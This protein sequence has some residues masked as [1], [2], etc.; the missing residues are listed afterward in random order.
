MI[1]LIYVHC[2]TYKYNENSNHLIAVSSSQPPLLPKQ[3]CFLS[4]PQFEQVNHNS[5]SKAKITPVK[6]TNEKR[7]VFFQIERYV[8]NLQ[9]LS[10][11]CHFGRGGVSWNVSGAYILCRKWIL[12]WG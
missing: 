10:L 5:K 7:G 6:S 1:V 4:F 2:I 8:R 11:R 3:N 9:L 12:H